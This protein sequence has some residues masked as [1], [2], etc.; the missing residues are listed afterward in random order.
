[1]NTS[2]Y[3]GLEEHRLDGEEVAGDDALGLRREEPTPGRAVPARCRPETRAT[4]DRTDRRGGDDDPQALELTLDPHAP[5]ARVLP[6][7][8]QDQGPGLGVDARASLATAMPVGPL[9][10]NELP[11]PPH[12]RGRGHDERRPA[13]PR[14][15][16]AHRR[17]EQLVPAMQL[18]ALDLPA[19]HGKL[20]AQDKY[21][22]FGI[23]GDPAQQENA[24]DDRVDE[25]VEHGGG[26]YEIGGPRTSP[27]SVPHR[28]DASTRSRWYRC[29]GR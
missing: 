7:H 8:A 18:G 2:T 13:L 17:E 19:K 4:K 14:Q 16:P 28:I 6:R 11:V 29:A 24:S 21:L 1:M 9:A 3:K 25:R 5:P 22:G 10:P 23:R 27:V 12:K 20:V 26:C 15:H